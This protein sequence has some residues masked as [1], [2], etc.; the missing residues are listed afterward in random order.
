MIDVI[1]AGIKLESPFTRH[2]TTKLATL[3]YD[4]YLSFPQLPANALSFMVHGMSN[5][6]SP[7]VLEI[8]VADQ[9]LV[10]VGRC[11]WSCSFL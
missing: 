4:C 9:A 8:L 3:M 2:S 7:A 10:W 6:Y 5:F 11:V 1:R